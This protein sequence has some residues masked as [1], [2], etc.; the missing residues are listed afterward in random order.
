MLGGA[1]LLYRDR[2]SSEP[3]SGIE[4]IVEALSATAGERFSRIPATPEFQ[5][6]RDHGSHGEYR[7]EWWL[8]T[9]MVTDEQA[10][11]LGLHL[12]FFRIGLVAETGKHAS[13]WGATELYAAT[14]SISHPVSGKLMERGRLSR[15]PLG[16]AGASAAPMEVWVENWQM[17]QIGGSTQGPDL[18]V[19]LDADD[20]GIHIILENLKPLTT[21]NEFQT[22]GV[23]GAAPF[24]FYMQPRLKVTGTYSFDDRGSTLSGTGTLE[25]AWG[26]LPLPGGAVARDRFTVHFDDSRELFCVRLR[27]VDEQDAASSN[28][29]LFA[30]E[31][32]PRTVS[33]RDISLQPDAYWR[34]ERTGKR[35]PTHWTLEIPSEGIHLKLLPHWDDQEGSAWLPFWSGPMRV[36]DVSG[37]SRSQGNAFIQLM[38][39]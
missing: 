7:T 11:S 30:P 25:H 17:E 2:Q 27:R 26:E 1:A 8:V 21:S 14:F 31:V 36:R 39:Y 20:V 4:S 33:S 19:K 10:R 5:F 28:C 32:P 24:Q 34:S 29:V 38:G 37:Q 23:R 13:R 12:A 15:A 3:H 18:R 9:A 35:Y 6:P 16:P 22:Q